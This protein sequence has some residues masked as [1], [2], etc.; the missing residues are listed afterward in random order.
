MKNIGLTFTI[1]AILVFTLVVIC[2]ESMAS[3]YQSNQ[4]SNIIN[5]ASKQLTK[6]KR[7][8]NEVFAIQKELNKFYGLLSED[9]CN[10]SILAK[11]CTEFENSGY[12]FVNLRFFDKQQSRLS[13][14]SSRLDDGLNGAMQRLYTALATSKL[15]GDDTMLKQYRSLFE[16]LL[17]AVDLH[18]LVKQTSTVIPVTLSGKPGY[19]YWNV[20]ENAAVENDI[21][22]MIAWVRKSD[23]PARFFCQKLVD[24][25]NQHSFEIGENQVFGFIDTNVN[26][27]LY[28][29]N[30]VDTIPGFYYAELILKLQ[31]LK[32]C[33]RS[34]DTIANRIFNYIELGNG[35]FFFCLSQAAD[36]TILRF[37]TYSFEGFLFISILGFSIYA[38]MLFIGINHK[39]EGNAVLYTRRFFTTEICTSVFLIIFLI[40]AN[41]FVGRLSRKN[42]KELV[43][44]NLT[45]V[46]DWLDDGFIL[47]KKELSEKWMN[48]AKDQSVVYMQHNAID[49]IANTMAQERQLT[50]M[51]IADKE[52]NLLYSYPRTQ[53]DYVFTR[54]IP[55]IA[56]KIAQERFGSEENWRNRIDSMMLNSF[57]QSFADLLGEGATDILKA[58]ETFDTATELDFGNKKHIVFSTTVNEKSEDPKLLIVWLDAEP[59]CHDYIVNKIKDAETLPANLRHTILAMVPVH[60]DSLPYPKEITK[61]SFT[62]DITERVTFTKRTV[63]FETNLAG[64]TFYGVGTLLNSAPNYVVFALQSP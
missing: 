61:Y 5:S 63:E 30:I 48:V 6:L 47:A 8:S 54:L 7:D 32:A 3:A 46:I 28:P 31:E 16:T 62:R 14:K 60:L 34:H 35:R 18:Q 44:T 45:S 9:N 13:I 49:N 33:L 43:Y 56:K 64:N 22:G 38:I 58:F 27:L 15:K 57:T 12:N 53:N 11:R 51:F 24:V 26:G 17:G 52:G 40:V 55:V 36:Y 50:K 42:H 10:P 59:Y 20:Y 29:E 2:I 1:S 25:Y 41:V 4:F 23:I 37:L 39:L 19:F 21:G